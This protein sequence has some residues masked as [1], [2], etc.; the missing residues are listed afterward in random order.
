[1]SGTGAGASILIVDDDAAVRHYLGRLLTRRGYAVQQIASGEA[2]L[3][4]VTA[5]RPD[6]VL[7]DVGL[8]GIDGIEVCRQL[9][10]Q[11]ATRLTPVVLMTG[12]DDYH[13]KMRG[14]VAGADDFVC[15]PFDEEEL[16]ARLASL[17]R[18]KRYT[19]ELE[20]ARGVM[21]TLA[22]TVE[23]RDHYTGGHCDRLASYATALG[24]R[25]RLTGG[26][27]EALS[28]GA[29]LHDIGKI[30]IPDAV[31]HKSS[32][33]TE[34][35][36]AVMQQHP[37]IGERLCAELH[38]LAPVLPIVRHHHERWDGS[39]YPDGLRGHAIPLL[40]QIVSIV[41]VYDAITTARPY[42]AA[43]SPQHAYEELAQ[44]A[45]SGLLQPA[46]VREFLDLASSDTVSSEL[47]GA[48]WTE[49]PSSRSR[50][51]SAVTKRASVTSSRAG[52]K[53]QATAPPR[54][55]M[56]RGPGSR[57]GP[58]VGLFPYEPQFQ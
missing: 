10:Q 22:L 18:L 9:K 12:G 41:D 27:L 26:E 54:S 45:T 50:S 49:A 6:L 17:V 37:A 56:H 8:P 55:N 34:T 43:A 33:L 1:M 40:A 52:R 16:T 4:A 38:S 48:V 35:E 42:R 47:Q 46:L 2:A 28:R 58:G 11:A 53:P 23:A 51:S 31:L 13:H 20:S 19:D 39:G 30:A 15:K 25:L 44:A 14:I 21:I 32:S 36:F 5:S 57:G 7:L 3:A 24:R 29:Y